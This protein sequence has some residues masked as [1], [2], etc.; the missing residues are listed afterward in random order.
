MILALAVVVA[1]TSVVYLA[2]ITDVHG[3][4]YGRIL[5]IMAA[6]VGLIWCGMVIGE[7]KST[8]PSCL[9]EDGGPELPCVWDGGVDENG[10]YVT[11]TYTR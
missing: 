4:S 8:I 6:M 10:L 11:I 1:L 9:A 7:H 5:L 3:L 2:T